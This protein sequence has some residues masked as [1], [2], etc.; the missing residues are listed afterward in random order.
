M[1]RPAEVPLL[2]CG[3]WPGRVLL[4][5]QLAPLLWVGTPGIRDPPD[6][7]AKRSWCECVCTCL[8]STSTSLNPGSDKKLSKVSGLRRVLVSQ[9]PQGTP[10]TTGPS[11]EEFTVLFVPPGIAF[12]LPPTPLPPYIWEESK[13]ACQQVSASEPP[14]PLTWQAFAESL[15]L[16]ES[17]FLCLS[18]GRVVRGIK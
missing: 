12:S 18:T 5:L 10:S 1:L 8:K 16:S 7:K 17:H 14:S 9:A 2:A 11:S 3:F 4:G 6:L 13:Q 15:S